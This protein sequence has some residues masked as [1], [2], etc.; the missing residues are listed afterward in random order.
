MKTLVA[1]IVGAILL[2]ALSLVFMGD[3][4]ARTPAPRTQLPPPEYHPGDKFSLPNE[5][6]C[7]SKAALLEAFT[8]PLNGNNGAPQQIR[9]GRLWSLS[10]GTR[11]WLQK[12]D[13]AFSAEQL[14]RLGL[15]HNG[16]AYVEILS[17]EYAGRGCWMPTSHWFEPLSRVR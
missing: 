11:L 5:A 8:S 6:I 7:G 15:Q 16:V 9:D 2:V 4:P 14:A 13:D 3:P 17:G 10:A 12:Y 1:I